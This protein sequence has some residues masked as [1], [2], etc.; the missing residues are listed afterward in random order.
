[1]ELF[2]HFNNSANYRVVFAEQ[3]LFQLWKRERESK[4]AHLK[5][6][7]SRTQQRRINEVRMQVGRSDNALRWINT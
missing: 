6:C 7:N 5:S 4:F 1:M 2:A 3:L